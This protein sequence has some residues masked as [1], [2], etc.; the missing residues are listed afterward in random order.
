MGSATS[1]YAARG[2]V[3]ACAR[4][5]V[6]TSAHSAAVRPLSCRYRRISNP[7]T[8]SA[9]TPSGRL[10]TGSSAKRSIRP[11]ETTSDAFEWASTATILAIP[12]RIS[13]TAVAIAKSPSEATVC[14]GRWTAPS[15]SGTYSS[16]MLVPSSKS[17]DAQTNESISVRASMPASA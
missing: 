1:A 15:W 4:F 6:A 13:M 3:A 11:C 8:A 5:R 12:E 10:S 9:G 17:S 14:T 2:F 16:K 7:A